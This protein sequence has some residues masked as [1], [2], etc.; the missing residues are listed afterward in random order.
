MDQAT[1]PPVVDPPSRNPF[2]EL[3]MDA[4]SRGDTDDDT[5]VLGDGL[6]QPLLDS[7][8]PPDVVAPPGALAVD[9]PPAPPILPLV[10]P[11]A[12]AS[13]DH[14]AAAVDDADNA[15]DPV[16]RTNFDAHDIAMSTAIAAFAEVSATPRRLTT[17]ATTPAVAAA[18]TP[19]DFLT[20]LNQSLARNNDILLAKVRADN[21]ARLEQSLARNNDILM[22]TV[23]ADNESS[24]ATT[25]QEYNT[26]LGCLNGALSSI[27]TQAEGIKRVNDRIKTP[28]TTIATEVRTSLTSDLAKTNQ[29]VEG[30]A[31]SVGHF[32]SEGGKMANHILTLRQDYDSR[33][34]S[35]ENR[36]TTIRATTPPPPPAQRPTFAVVEHPDDDNAPS[37]TRGIVS[38]LRTLPHQQ[39]TWRIV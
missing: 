24:H 29:R 16:V 10:T 3:A 38:V 19:M 22:A 31:S 35:L 28:T 5:T 32:S 15:I 12:T 4:A 6:L 17:P 33:I 25:L 39:W 23:H 2:E 27:D 8:T 9:D 30:R 20:L 1:V 18:M 21:D 26:I 34:A 11:P 14:A 36:I 13:P 37:R 7:A